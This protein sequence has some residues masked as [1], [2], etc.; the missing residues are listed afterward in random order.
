MTYHFDRKQLVILVVC[1][2]L[3]IV[4]TYAAG[5]VTG[6][7]MVIPTRE[8]LALLKA[9]RPASSATLAQAHLPGAVPAP[10]LPVTPVPQ[11]AAA[12]RATEPASI[13]AP[14]A[15]ATPAAPP[16]APPA[17]A[18][19]AAAPPDD[20]DGFSLQVGSFREPKNARQLQNDLK[21]RGYATSVLTALDA[22]QR[23]W[24]VVRI[25][26][27]KTLASAARAAADFS[28]KERIQAL[29][30]RSNSL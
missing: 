10:A 13:P 5:V 7:A 23:E 26:G 17:P 6:V 11:P 16:T 20:T 25:D 4:F 19:A 21:E 15:P 29:V 2:G 30:R 3:V 22:E 18:V 24:H 8:E 12:T 9:G 27:Y 28:G 1:L 14:G